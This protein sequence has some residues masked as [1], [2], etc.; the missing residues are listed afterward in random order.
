MVESSSSQDRESPI[1]NLNL[2]HLDQSQ[3]G[4]KQISATDAG[5][6]FEIVL[7][8]TLDGDS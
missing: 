6:G 4:N 2:I 3:S 8:F 5:S 7:D 1:N